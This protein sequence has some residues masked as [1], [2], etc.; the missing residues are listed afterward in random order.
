M[1]VM[2]QFNKPPVALTPG[3]KV[4]PVTFAL[5]VLVHP[6]VPVVVSTYVPAVST[7][8][9]DT[10]EANPLGPV[11]E[12]VAPGAEDPVSV[13]VGVVQLIMPPTFMVAPGTALSSVTTAVAVAVQ[14]FTW[15]VTVTT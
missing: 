4:S 11:Q 6:L 9:F 5:A 1:E 7:T 14:L 3:G 13:T 8:G 10:V 15:L 2:A 12:K